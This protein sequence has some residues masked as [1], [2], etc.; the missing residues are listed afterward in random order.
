MELTALQQL[1]HQMYIAYY[2]RPADP[3]GLQY[4]VDQLE[5]NGDWTAVSGAFGAPENEENQALYGDMTREETIS[6]IYQSAFNRAAVDAE[7]QFWADSDFSATDL[8]FA[9]I[10]GAQNDDLTTVNN[11]VEFSALLVQQLET[12]AAYAQLENPKALL[13]AV[14]SET[15][16]TAEYAS[17]VVGSGVVGETFTLTEALDSLATAKAEKEAFLESALENETLAEN[18]DLDEDSTTADA[19]AAITAELN[20]QTAAVGGDDDV[21][22]ANFGDRSASIQDSLIA[23]AVSAKEEVLSDAVEEAAEGTEDRLAAV[24]AEIA[25]T[26]ASIDAAAETEAALTDAITVFNSLSGVAAIDADDF[27]ETEG[28][29]GLTVDGD[30]VAERTDGEWTL[31]E[32]GETADYKRL[33]ELF[34]AYDEDVAADEAVVAAK[35]QLEAAVG[36]V[37]VAEEEAY[38]AFNPEA[39]VNYA[40]T[41]GDSNIT[42]DFDTAVQVFATKALADADAAGVKEVFT[43]TVN[44]AGGVGET[45]TF[46]GVTYTVADAADASAEATATE[47]AT[48]YNDAAGTDWVVERDGAE[49]TFT[50]K[51]AAAD[52]DNDAAVTGDTDVTVAEVTAG[53]A[54]DQGT[55]ATAATAD[56]SDDVYEAQMAVDN[57]NTLVEEYL[58]AR[59]LNDG[60]ESADEAI[61]AADA[62]LTDSEEDGGLGVNL[63]EGAENFTTN[64]DVY[65]F[66]AEHGDEDLTNFGQTGED[67]IYFGEGFSLVELGDD[68]ITDNVGDSSAMEIFWEEEGSNLNLYVEAETFGGNS[69]GES[70]VTKITLTGVSAEDITDDLGTGFLT[71]GQ[72]A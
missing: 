49:L 55:D 63:L 57:F 59:E 20:T 26:N 43:A 52:I 42:V 30:I 28:V 58:N 72:V 13:T 24:K 36:D 40:L 53:V 54:A 3:E 38:S 11:K 4:W 66:D 25:A 46:D 10:N 2:Q 62:A 29:L 47:F 64:N 33:D 1:V 65:L 6:A 68:A 50:A 34:T 35:E 7:V 60:L 44:A 5:Q 23:E 48:L 15:D 12:N 16:V 71:A 21:D 9:I 61:E 32:A 41:D 45:L 14:T 39:A 56:L 19:E 27:A 69:A 17:G 8:T 67:K 31:T 51:E 37:Y 70:D 22:D 18:Q